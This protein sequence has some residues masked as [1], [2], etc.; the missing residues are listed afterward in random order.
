MEGRPIGAITIDAQDIFDPSQ[1][2]ENHWIHRLA[3]KLHYQTK[4]PTVERKLLFTEGDSFSQR[5]LDESERLLRKQRYLADASIS[6][7]RICNEEVWV[8]VTTTDTWSTIPE[9]SLSR[10]GGESQTK[11]ALEEHNLLGLGQDLSFSYEK[12]LGRVS[13]A[14]SYQHNDWAGKHQSLK[15]ELQNNEDGERYHFAL[16]K[17]FIGLSDTYGWGVNSYIDRRSIDLYEAGEINETM[18]QRQ[19]YLDINRRWSRGI[20]LG[21]LNRWT[22]GVRFDMHDFETVTDSQSEVAFE[23]RREI[24]PYISL[25][26]LQEKFIKMRH[27]RQLTGVEDINLGNQYHV[28]LGYSARAWGSDNDALVLEANF[29]R[30][31]RW[32]QKT[33]LLGDTWASTNLTSGKFEQLNIGA[34]AQLHR[35]LSDKDQI[36]V[37]LLIDSQHAETADRQLTI[38]GDNGLRGYPLKAQNGNRLARLTLEIRH[39]PDWHPWHLLRFG[40]AFFADYG[41]AWRAGSASPDW[42]WDLGVGLR[43][44]SSRSSSGRVLHLDLAVP[45]GSGSAQWTATAKLHF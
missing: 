10:V 5:V 40:A 45:E 6:V 23:D 4:N 43:L 21:L 42:L 25:G 8:N 38:G 32:S 30:G 35:Q 13:R 3:N 16:S 7:T 2:S 41:A 20:K 11:I 36:F 9:I 17:P 44:G 18:G 19:Q 27:V 15:L 1:S 28:Q 22:A 26:H 29:Q 31:Y 12:E 37:E 14:L 33:L 39:Y 34:V 24:Y